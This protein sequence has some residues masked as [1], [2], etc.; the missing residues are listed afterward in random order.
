MDTQRYGLPTLMA[1]VAEL[2]ASGGGMVFT[3]GCFD[4]LHVG[5]VRYLQAARRLGDWLVVGLNSDR[6]VRALKGPERPLVPEA[7]R[8][9][10][11]AALAC[12]DAVV[13]FDSPTAESLVA[14][15]QPEVYVKVDDYQL[16][17][18]P[19][20]RIV[21]AYGGRVALLPTV[22]GAS[23]TALIAR[24]RRPGGEEGPDPATASG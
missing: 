18:L 8:A 19:E 24:I 9:E 17:T 6:S 5:H 3:N 20:A 1:H 13:I 11:L 23:T 12:V 7:E 2:R 14:R 22:A 21:Q 16:E 10:V 15:L 4:L